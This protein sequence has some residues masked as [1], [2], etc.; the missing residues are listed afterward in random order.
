MNPFERNTAKYSLHENVY[1]S[2]VDFQ[3]KKIED[4]VHSIQYGDGYLDILTEDRGAEATLIFFHGAVPWR[5]TTIPVFSGRSVTNGLDANMILV[6][7]PSLERTLNLAWFVGDRERRLQHDLPRVLKHIMRSF[8][9]HNYVITYG[10][11]G[12]GF[13]SLFYSTFLENA[14]AIAANPQT[15]I[16]NYHQQTVDRFVGAT[17]PGETI[18]DVQAV[19]DVSPLYSKPLDNAVIYVQALGDDHVEL[20][21]KPFLDSISPAN[22]YGIRFLWNGKGHIPPSKDSISAMLK[23]VVA[24]RGDWAETETRLSLVNGLDTADI[25]AMQRQYMAGLA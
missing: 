19:T 5:K 12:G 21:M 1:S 18:N 11:S 17:W 14:I 13:A 7:D 3:N 4:G 20:H 16:A 9:N 10:G 22:R 15:N 23:E 24:C 2:L 25:L 6:S 8:A